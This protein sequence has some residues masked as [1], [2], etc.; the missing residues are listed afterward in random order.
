GYTPEPLTPKAAVVAFYD[1]IFASFPDCR[2][3]V[4]QMLADGDHLTMRFRFTGTHDGP[5]VGLPATGR[6]FEV[7]GITILR[8][9]GARCVERGARAD[10]LTLLFQVGLPPPPP[11]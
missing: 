11:A 10:F 6:P 3:T 1:R 2:V 4:E 5:F 8:F 7:S 9:A